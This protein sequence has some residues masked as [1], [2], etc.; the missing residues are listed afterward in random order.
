M[1]VYA[2]V[3]KSGTGKSYQAGNLCRDKNIESIIDD[4]LYIYRINSIFGKS[5]KQAETMMGAIKTALFTEESHRDEVVQAI[6]DTQPGSILI[7]GTSD[8]MVAKITKR[9]GLPPIGETIYINDIT[10]EED[11]ETAHKQRTVQGK[12]VVPV[13]QAHLKKRFSGYFMVPLRKFLAWGTGREEGDNEKTVV[14][15]T[16]SYLGEFFISQQVIEDI[17]TIIGEELPGV[18]RILNVTAE[19][20]SEQLRVKITANFNTTETIVE[21]AKRMQE[22]C[23]YRME[24]MTALAVDQINIQ[25]KEIEDLKETA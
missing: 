13:P 8:G 10:T 15:P 17:V 7:I 2:L 24:E 23:A 19:K 1:K 4:G 11:R 5:A 12:H 25:V 16:Y 21:T 3:G 14:R 20:R 6:E 18:T 22:K 9:L